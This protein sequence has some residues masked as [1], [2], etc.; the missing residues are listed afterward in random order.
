MLLPVSR[1]G[2]DDRLEVGRD[3]AHL[4]Q[5]ATRGAEDGGDV[6]AGRAVQAASTAEGT[7]A[8]DR[9]DP[10]ARHGAV[11]GRARR[12]GPARA[13]PSMVKCR[14]KTETTCAELVRRDRLQ[15]VVGPEVVAGLGAEPAVDAGLQVRGLGLAQLAAEDRQAALEVWRASAAR[16][17]SSSSSSSAMARHPALDPGQARVRRKRAAPAE[18]GPPCGSAW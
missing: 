18:V 12:R 2:G 11:E 1:L 6:D 14:L 4:G 3:E 16:A 8:E 7:A 17:A 13:C 5:R 9:L 15:L 10:L